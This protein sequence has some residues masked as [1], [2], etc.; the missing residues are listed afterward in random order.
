MTDE[1]EP[2]IPTLQASPDADTTILFTS[3][4]EQGIKNIRVKRL[5]CLHG[6]LY[7]FTF[8][9]EIAAGSIVDC[10]I[11][12]T[13]NGKN[14]FVIDALDASLRYPQDFSYFIQN[15]SFSLNLVFFIVCV[16]NL[17]CIYFS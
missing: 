5:L 12:F 6:Y 8:I 7:C 15:V 4:P 13:N 11:G 17:T 10:L 9:L 3:H 14:D 1:E 16:Y 2:E